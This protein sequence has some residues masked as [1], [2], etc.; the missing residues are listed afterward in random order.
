V[1][2]F[3]AQLHALAECVDRLAPAEI[4]GE[5]ERL[6]F[7][8]W[9]TMTPPA[10]AAP[11]PGASRALTVKDV[12]ARTGMSKQSVYRKTRKNQLPFARRIG[13]RLA[14]D[15]AGLERWWAAQRPR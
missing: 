5:L 10:P 11:E 8:L 13:R 9:Q 3:A 6:R 2:D 12:M 14:Y 7:T 15:E 1:P 4:A